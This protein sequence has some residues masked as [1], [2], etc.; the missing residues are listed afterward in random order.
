LNVKTLVAAFAFSISA[1]ATVSEPVSVLD[2]AP[3][4]GRFVG[5]YHLT[6]NN[7]RNNNRN[8]IRQ[9]N[10]QNC[11]DFLIIKTAKNHAGAPALRIAD[12]NDWYHYDLIDQSHRDAITPTSDTYAAEAIQSSANA[13]QISA[14][15]TMSAF[16][17]NAAMISRLT[18]TRDTSGAIYV[19]DEIL[20][21][22]LKDNVVLD[23]HYEPM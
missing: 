2:F 17:S 18:V 6:T 22:A 23:C 8:N 7:N 20:H 19:H 4:A 16:A 13:I 21:S 3:A 15:E 12:E 1:H 9:N 11:P 10:R 5:S 14:N